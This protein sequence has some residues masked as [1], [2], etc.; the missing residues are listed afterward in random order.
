MPRASHHSHA[1]RIGAYSL[2]AKYGNDTAGPARD[3][4]L[5]RFEDEVDPD[6]ALTPDERAERA[7]AALKAHMARL[8]MRS[9]QSRAR[10][11]GR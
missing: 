7:Q 9:A 3:A 11:A 10:G 5:R 1:G 4:F 6:R 8:A 2:H